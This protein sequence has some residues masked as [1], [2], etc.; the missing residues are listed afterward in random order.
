MNE[1]ARIHETSIEGLWTV[2][3]EIHSDLRGET[4]E[5]MN[6]KWF[7]PQMPKLNFNQ[8]LLASSHRGTIRGIHIAAKTN[9]QL[10]LITCISGEILDCIVDFRPES[11][12]FREILTFELSH[13]SNTALLLSPGLGHAYQVIS[14]SATVFYSLQTQLKF[15]EEF[16]VNA[17]DKELAIPWKQITPI[18]SERDEKAPDF[19]IAIKSFTF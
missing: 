13:K 19:D 1:V 2:S 3:N 18:L 14:E 6:M 4:V 11:P 7:Q 17:F 8:T 12:T 15:S 9:P 5:L 10:K 16:C